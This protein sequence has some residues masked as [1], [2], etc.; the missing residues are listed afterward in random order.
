MIYDAFKR[1][2][3]ME[4]YHK[5]KPF[6]LAYGYFTTEDP[7][8]TELIANTTDSY[9]KKKPLITDKLV[10]KVT[11]GSSEALTALRELG[12]LYCSKNTVIGHTECLLFFPEGYTNLEEGEG[13]EEE[14]VEVSK[15]KKKRKKKKDEESS[16]VRNG[17][18]V[19]DISALD[20]APDTA[21]EKTSPTEEKSA[22]TEEH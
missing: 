10:L 18:E 12:P 22:T 4:V 13:V 15:K 19:A 6:M 17:E 7:H 14:V 2:D 1:A 8:A 5:F 20:E 3:I 11:K 21:D 16:S 9:L